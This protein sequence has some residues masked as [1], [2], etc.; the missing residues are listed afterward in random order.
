MACQCGCSTATT[1][2]EAPQGEQGACGCAS[3]SPESLDVAALA[4]LVRELDQ[5]VRELE[6]QTSRN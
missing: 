6:L 5:R 4:R 1:T 3:P 2:A